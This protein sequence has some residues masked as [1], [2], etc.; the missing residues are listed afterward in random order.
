MGV[1]F[2]NH[3]SRILASVITTLALLP[4]CAMAGAPS[5]SAGEVVSNVPQVTVEASTKVRDVS[6]LLVTIGD[7]LEP[8]EIVVGSNTYTLLPQFKSQGNAISNIRHNK[9]VAEL[10]SHY[11]LDVISDSNW[12][13]YRDYCYEYLD[14]QDRPEWYS[15]GSRD[16]FQLFQFFDIYENS[17]R[18]EEAIKIATTSDSRHLSENQEF[19]SLLPSYSV[20]SADVVEEPTVSES[21]ARVP[22]LATSA[23]SGFNRTAA[24]S[25]A[26]KYATNPNTGSYQYFPNGDC[27]NFASQIM[28]NAGV[29]QTSTWWHRRIGWIHQHSDTWVNADKFARYTGLSFITSSNSQFS[30]YMKTYDFIAADYTH[31]GTWD[32]IGF[33]VNKRKTGSSYDYNVAQHTANYIAWSSSQTNGWDLIGSSGGYYGIIHTS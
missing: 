2:I 20:T 23:L 6:P 11:G 32:H 29:S 27:A 12:K 8:S 19:L 22:V 28:E 33:V 13:Q 18:N 24:N 30:N 5:A 25:Y 21:A 7:V 16:V 14:A 26:S 31:D 10:Q 4:F 3:R 1:S 9:A 17:E 15:E